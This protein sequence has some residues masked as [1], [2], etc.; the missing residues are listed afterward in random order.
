[1]KSHGSTIEKLKLGSVNNKPIYFKVKDNTI[2]PKNK[3]C[4][5]NQVVNGRVSKTDYIE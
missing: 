1:M 4:F 2:V 3:T 5:K